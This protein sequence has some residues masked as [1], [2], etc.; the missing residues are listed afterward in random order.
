MSESILVKSDIL[1]LKGRDREMGVSTQ[2]KREKRAEYLTQENMAR[3]PASG[4]D[5][6]TEGKLGQWEWLEQGGR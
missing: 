5:Q 4:A 2:A 6:W 3:P 1:P